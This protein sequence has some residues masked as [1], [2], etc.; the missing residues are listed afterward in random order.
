MLMD[1]HKRE[2]MEM[3]LHHQ[4]HSPEL[5]AIMMLNEHSIVE[6]ILEELNLLHQDSEHGEIFTLLNN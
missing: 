3:D 6:F 5:S 4:E 2:L 1:L